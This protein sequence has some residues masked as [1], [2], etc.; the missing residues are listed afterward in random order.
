MVPDP[1][2][3]RTPIVQPAWEDGLL[4]KSSGLEIE[5]TRAIIYKDYQVQVESEKQ[6]CMACVSIDLYYSGTQ[7][8]EC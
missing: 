5:S 2:I 4:R 8:N 6:G 3:Y 1:I 7:T